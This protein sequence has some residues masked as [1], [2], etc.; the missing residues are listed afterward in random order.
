VQVADVR[1]SVRQETLWI[2]G[3][4]AAGGTTSCS[5]EYW[6]IASSGT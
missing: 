4:G 1:D 5:T 3:V 6:V 2:A